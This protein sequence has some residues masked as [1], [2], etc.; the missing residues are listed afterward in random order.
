MNLAC[1]FMVCTNDT[2]LLDREG[3]V[4]KQLKEEYKNYIN[5][6]EGRWPTNK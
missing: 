4:H 5:C 3:G 2:I 6:E 1:P